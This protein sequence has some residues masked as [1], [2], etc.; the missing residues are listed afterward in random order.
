MD[1]DIRFYRDQ[2]HQPRVQ[3]YPGHQALAN[4][5]ESDLQDSATISAVLAALEQVTTGKDQELYGNSY[6]VTMRPDEVTLESLFDDSERPTRLPAQPFK[7]LL[8]AW[9]DFL[10]NEN[11]ISIVPNF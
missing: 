3:G 6:T 11:L 1:A 4:C 2:S 8:T 9:L 10:D 5:L 7:S